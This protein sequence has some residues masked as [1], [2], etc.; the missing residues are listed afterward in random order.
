MANCFSCVGRFHCV[1]S[2]FIV[3]QG[4]Q[5]RWRQ[6]LT[7]L[8]FRQ[9]PSIAQVKDMFEL[10]FT[11]Y[12]FTDAQIEPFFQMGSKFYVGSTALSL[13]ERQ[14]HRL[15]RFR[16][17]RDFKPAHAELMRHWT[18]S[19]QRFRK[20]V[21]IPI[22]KMDT[23]RHIRTLESTLIQKW[24]PPLNYPFI[25]QKRISKVGLDYSQSVKRIA[26][27]Y[28]SPGTILHRSVVSL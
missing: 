9:A 28:Q 18:V 6:R 5:G 19:R 2:A 24:N 22:A 14:D 16:Q 12:L 20:M 8:H 26:S 7:E 27:S 13:Q 23:R 3:R 15:R 10:P 4:K 25:L 17:L 21:L 11:T 1:V